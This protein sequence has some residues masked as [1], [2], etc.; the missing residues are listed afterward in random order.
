MGVPNK[1]MVATAS[2][3]PNHYPPGSLWRQTGQPLGR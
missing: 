2:T 3:S 1:P